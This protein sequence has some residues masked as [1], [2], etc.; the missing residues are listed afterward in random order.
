MIEA[1]KSYDGRKLT[2]H[3][4]DTLSVS[5][6]ENPSTG[7][8]WDLKTSPSRNSKSLPTHSK[9]AEVPPEQ[10][11][12]TAGNGKQR[13][14]ARRRFAWNTA[15]LGRRTRRQARSLL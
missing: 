2:L 3:V 4:G 6:A 14:Q 11:E 13:E 12:P 8:R 15:G 1:D 9:A 10:E 7:F 5:L